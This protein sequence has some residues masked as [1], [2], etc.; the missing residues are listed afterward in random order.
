MRVTLQMCHLGVGHTTVIYSLNFELVSLSLVPS[1]AKRSLSFLE[2]RRS[3]VAE[4]CQSF[5]F[6][7][8][9]LI[10]S[11]QFWIHEQM[12]IVNRFRRLYTHMLIKIQIDM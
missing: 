11:G 7:V 2:D 5:S 4:K 9:C 3:M 10:P 8:A 1:A 6:C 12:C